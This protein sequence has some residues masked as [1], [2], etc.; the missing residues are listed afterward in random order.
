MKR[1]R[2]ARLQKDFLVLSHKLKPHLNRIILINEIL[3]EVSALEDITDTKSECVLLW[4]QRLE[5]Q[6]V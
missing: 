6:R 5:T 3:R 2:N 4:V 1:K